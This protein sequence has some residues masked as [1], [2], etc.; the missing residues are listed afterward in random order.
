[1]SIR[2]N[3]QASGSGPPLKPVTPNTSTASS[4]PPLQRFARTLQFRMSAVESSVMVDSAVAGTEPNA[5]EASGTPTKSTVRDQVS[6]SLPLHQRRPTITPPSSQ[7]VWRRGEVPSACQS[8]RKPSGR[9]SSLSSRT[10][11]ILCGHLATIITTP[12]HPR[13]MWC[14]TDTCMLAHIVLPMRPWRSCL[15]VSGT[16]Y[17]M[18]AL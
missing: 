17:H 13:T 1:M 16:F 3:L 11:V 6:L 10:V 8:T 12:L 5:E 15:V 4:R 14:R 9:S 2:L 18:S 7:K